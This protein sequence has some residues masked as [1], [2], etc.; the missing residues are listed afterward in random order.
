M[1]IISE[2]VNYK[3]GIFTFNYK[4]DDID[5]VIK[6]ESIKDKVFFNTR[7]GVKI[8]YGYTFTEKATGDVKRNFLHAI[9]DKKIINFDY[10]NFILESVRR[11]ATS[12]NLDNIDAILT[13]KSGSP[14]ASEIAEK[15]SQKSKA[16][17]IN[18]AIVKN[19][20]DKIKIDYD[21]YNKNAKTDD[22]KVKRTKQLDKDYKYATKDGGF[23]IKKVFKPHAKFFSNFL[24]LNAQEKK[25][26]DKIYGKSILIVDDYKVSGI[27][28]EELIKVVKQLNP[29]EIF[30]YVLIKR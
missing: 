8:Y 22:E 30:I 11:L 15:I 16:L 24:S 12:I 14:L 20:I 13:P 25:S 21:A 27:T 7:L 18:G 4:K 10:S 23:Q 29:K 6:L 2:G 5:D 17:L 1:K 3:N 9:K 26:L 28:T 19:T